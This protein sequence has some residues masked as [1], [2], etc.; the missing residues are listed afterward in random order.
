MGSYIGGSREGN[1][2]NKKTGGFSPVADKNDTG[3]W[4]FTV[5]PLPEW[6]EEKLLR[7]AEEVVKARGPVSAEGPTR[8]VVAVSCED[9]RLAVID[10]T[11]PLR[12]CVEL[13]E[14]WDFSLKLYSRKEYGYSRDKIPWSGFEV[15]SQV[16]VFLQGGEEE[17]KRRE[18]TQE[19]KERKM[20]IGVIAQNVDAIKI[21]TKKRGLLGVAYRPTSRGGVLVIKGKYAGLFAKGRLVWQ[22]NEGDFRGELLGSYCGESPCFPWLTEYLKS[23]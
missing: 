8:V 10:N 17:E 20:V 2:L 3:M 6:L 23:L 9:R 11:I 4:D 19:E 13:V 14:G 18:Q 7:I 15:L 5:V 1:P 16:K 22:G 21:F 12:Y